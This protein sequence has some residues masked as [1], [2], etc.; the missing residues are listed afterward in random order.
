M[1]T[2]IRFDLVCERLAV[3]AEELV[4]ANANVHVVEFSPSA[5]LGPL[6]LRTWRQ[7]QMMRRQQQQQQ[8]QQ[9]QEWKQQDGQLRVTHFLFYWMNYAATQGRSR[10]NPK[11][12][13]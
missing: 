3:I 13:R 12:N 2:P 8:Q 7:R 5:S 6:V 11:A 10:S 1:T 9:Q 4:A